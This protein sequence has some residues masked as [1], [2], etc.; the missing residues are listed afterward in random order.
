MPLASSSFKSLAPSGPSVTLRNVARSGR[1]YGRSNTSN[2]LTPI[3]PNFEFEGASICTA[4]AAQLPIS[5]ASGTNTEKP[6]EMPLPVSRGRRKALLHRKKRGAE[7]RIFAFRIGGIRP[8]VF[9]KQ[10]ARGHRWHV[11]LALH[12]DLVECPE[13]GFGRGH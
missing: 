4:P 7:R 6:T 8:S 9:L 12:D 13:I 10:S 3:G 5:C 2:S 1:M 11:A